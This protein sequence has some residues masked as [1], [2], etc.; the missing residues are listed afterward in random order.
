MHELL[1][2]WD[3]T[4]E[5][6]GDCRYDFNSV[7]KEPDVYGKGNLSAMDF[8]MCGPRVGRWW[9]ADKIVKVHES[10]YAAFFNNPINYADPSGLSGKKT[11][12]IC[13]PNGDG[14]VD[15]IKPTEDR[16]WSKNCNRSIGDWKN[17][18]QRQDQ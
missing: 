12:S 11:G 1:P 17:Y 4:P 8:R 9:G 5:P 3:A 7:E 15:L 10:P 14:T 16:L 13:K 2:I 18:F 6:D